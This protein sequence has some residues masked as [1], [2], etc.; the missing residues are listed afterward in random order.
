MNPISR[1]E[2][3]NENEG[4]IEFDSTSNRHVEG[5]IRGFYY[6]VPRESEGVGLGERAKGRAPPSSSGTS[7]RRRDI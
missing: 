3:E 4:V 2:A 5:N 6:A 1:S 7:R